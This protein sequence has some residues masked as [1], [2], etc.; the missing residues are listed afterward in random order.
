VNLLCYID[1]FVVDL[2]R[3]YSAVLIVYAVVSWIPD[4]RG[5]WT[6]YLSMLVDPVL[7]PIRRVI[8]P[9]GGLDLAFLVLILVLNFVL[10]PLVNGATANACYGY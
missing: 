3:L 5:S 7:N 9:V 8:P 1:Q 4:L 6:R 10:V 2:I